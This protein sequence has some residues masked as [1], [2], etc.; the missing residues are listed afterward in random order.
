MRRS[1]SRPNRTMLPAHP[2]LRGQRDC[3]THGTVADAG[4]LVDLA[5][6]HTV[7]LG[8]HENAE[9][10]QRVK[11]IVHPHCA[12]LDDLIPEIFLMYQ[13]CIGGVHFQINEDAHLQYP[14]SL[15]TVFG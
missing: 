11:R 9:A 3:I 8:P 15:P 14:F 6:D 2:V 5:L 1:R 12:D 7:V 4:K 10:V 13:T